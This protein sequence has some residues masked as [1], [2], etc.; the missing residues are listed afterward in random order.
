MN[1]HHLDEQI[2]HLAPKH[3]VIDVI[4]IRVDRNVVPNFLLYGRQEVGIRLRVPEWAIRKLV[5]S[6]KSAARD[7]SSRAAELSGS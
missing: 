2:S 6:A 1:L 5:N 7:V 4:V 3:R